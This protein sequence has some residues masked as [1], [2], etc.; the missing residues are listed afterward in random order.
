MPDERD[1]G[2]RRQTRSHSWRIGDV[3]YQL[4]IVVEENRMIIC[5]AYRNVNQVNGSNAIER[6][7]VNSENRE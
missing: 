2:S 4:N 1:N 3:Q 5:V 6:V 7:Q